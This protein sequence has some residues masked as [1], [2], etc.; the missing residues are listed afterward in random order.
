VYVA[1]CK[2]EYSVKAIYMRYVWKISWCILKS[3]ADFFWVSEKTVIFPNMEAKAMMFVCH[4]MTLKYAV[5]SNVAISTSNDSFANKSCSQ[6]MDHYVPDSRRL[7]CCKEL[8]SEFERYWQR[9]GTSL[10]RY[11][12]ALKSWN[13][14]LYNEECKKG[15]FRFNRFSELVYDHSCD[16]RKFVKTCQAIVQMTVD[17]D[18][19]GNSSELQSTAYPSS[20]G[21]NNS[22]RREWDLI[23]SRLN[24][25][26]LLSHHAL[27]KPCVQ[28]AL[29]EAGNRS[30]YQELSSVHLPTCNVVWCG[31]NEEVIATGQ[32]SLWTCLP[33]R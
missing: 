1:L 10:M 17:T 31:F 20:Y 18:P 8:Q 13:C 16:N 19:S 27:T 21:V 7:H 29:Y 3:F 23:V 22:Y 14:P 24:S 15:T 5:S 12:E 4:L 30:T 32:I 33:Q 2:I 11:L 6:S 9:P 26:F 28:A 25:T